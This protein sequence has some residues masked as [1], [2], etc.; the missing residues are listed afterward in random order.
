MGMGIDAFSESSTLLPDLQ[1]KENV[2][3][4]SNQTMSSGVLFHADVRSI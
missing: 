4:L 1:A 3:I 2:L